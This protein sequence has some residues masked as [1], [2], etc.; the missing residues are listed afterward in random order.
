VVTHS[1]YAPVAAPVSLGLLLALPSVDTVD[2]LVPPTL[3]SCSLALGVASDPRT[4]RTTHTCAVLVR[5]TWRPPCDDR[6]S[7]SSWTSRSCSFP[8][9]LLCN[10]FLPYTLLLSSHKARGA[11][12]T[13]LLI[14]RVLSVAFST[15]KTCGTNV[16]STTSFRASKRHLQNQH[17]PSHTETLASCSVLWRV[18]IDSL[19]RFSLL[20]LPL[21][22]LPPCL[23]S[24]ALP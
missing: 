20:L 3:P 15:A 6:S 21:I 23:F 2:T 24:N 16:F 17:P 11:H 4:V 12:A 7:L 5:C 14:P 9:L 22:T 8:S 18:T 10:P 13:P 19:A 1:L